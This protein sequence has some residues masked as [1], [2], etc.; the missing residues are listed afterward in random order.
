VAIFDHLVCS[1]SQDFQR[2]CNYD[3]KA[4]IHV[5]MDKNDSI[6]QRNSE[7]TSQVIRWRRHHQNP[8]PNRGIKLRLSRQLD[9]DYY[10]GQSFHL[11]HGGTQ[12]ELRHENISNEKRDRKVEAWSYNNRKKRIAML[13]ERPLIFSNSHP[14]QV[15][16]SAFFSA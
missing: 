1:H 9:S 11:L 12:Q 2:I 8:V 7:P 10:D 6:A 4:A 15:R 5:D 3:P 16:D 13:A 14:L